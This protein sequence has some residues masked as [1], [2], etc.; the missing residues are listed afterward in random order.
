M[1]YLYLTEQGSVLRKAGDRFLVEKDDEVLLDLPYHK[2]ENVLLFGNV[3]VTTQALGELLEK[4]VCLSLFSRQGSYRGSLAPPRG[5]HVLLRLAQF[6]TL[7]QAPAALAFA[8]SIVAAKIFNGLEVLAR[9]REKNPVSGEFDARTALIRSAMEGC[10]G[11]ADIA[12]L[13]GVEGAAARAYFTCVMEFNRSSLSWPGRRKHP[14]VDPLNALLSLGYT[15][16]MHELT[17]LLEG[18][19]L[20][21]YVGYLHQPDRGRPS[22]A[23]DLMEPFR[24]PLVDRLVLLLVNRGMIKE[25]DFHRSGEGGGLFLAPGPQRKFFAEYERWML[26][27]AP[28]GAPAGPRW[29]ELL[30]AEVERLATAFG[31]GTPFEPFRW[32]GKAS[33]PSEPPLEG[34]CNTSSVTI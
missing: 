15:L 20:D 9:Y 18:A 22:L 7:R 28:G 11:A 32:S 31:K 2:L 25:G 13:D 17:S 12:A 30:K 3:Q 6:D 27:K 1:A 19:G 23:L 26:D 24:H 34:T 33:T 21:P 16:L 29:R 14:S 5:H 10:A 8:R 4:G